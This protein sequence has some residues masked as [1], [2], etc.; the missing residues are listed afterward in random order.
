MPYLRH[1]T[2]SVRP[3]PKRRGVG[4]AQPGSS[5]ALG[6]DIAAAW[7]QC[8]WYDI[9]CALQ[10]LGTGTSSYE[11]DLYPVTA[12]TLSPGSVSPGLPSGYSDV[13][14]TGDIASNPTGA[15]QA[16]PYTVNYPNLGPS[17][18]PPPPTTSS[19]VMSLFSGEP[20]L[21]GVVGV[22]TLAV[23]VIGTI[24]IFKVAR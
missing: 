13:S 3:F 15:T 20:C 1:N 18:N 22:F 17:S 24:L 14:A 16:N 9:V 8:P 6:T 12:P 5:G 2:P 21:G 11:S 23:G 4:Q 7:N 19:C 10:T